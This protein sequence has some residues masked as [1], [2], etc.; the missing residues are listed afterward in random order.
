MQQTDALSPRSNS[1]VIELIELYLKTAKEQRW[2][3]VAIAMTA[4]PNL[5]ACD[6]A[7]DVAL[8]LAQRDALTLL[9]GKVQESIDN[10]SLP[11]RDE[12]LDASYACYSIVNAP[13]G[14][15][16]ITWLI[17]Q[18]M[19]RVRE[20]AP[21]PLKVG[22]W[23]G[24]MHLD[25]Q[26]SRWLENV[27]R[28]ALKLIG[29][30][31][32]KKAVYGRHKPLYVARDIVAAVKAGEK[33]PVLRSTIEPFMLN[34]VTITLREAVYDPHRN[35][36][37]PA[38]L[39][40]AK[41]LTDKGEAVIFVRDTDKAEERLVDFQT[42]PKASRDLDV[43]MSLYENAKANLFVQN[44]PAG[45]AWY[46]KAPWLQFEDA[47]NDSVFTPLWW[48]MSQGINPGEQFP[49]SAENQRMVWKSDTYENLVSAWTSLAIN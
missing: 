16:F 21:A 9:R 23:Q 8:E 40:F 4:Y 47:G 11:D 43:R 15:D 25:R 31:E 12:T 19:I 27:F 3:H 29:A 46:S 10:W 17:D 37:L 20:G 13:I 6:Y 44:G 48:K 35:S 36:N 45:L 22:F 1:A 34:H 33:T 49:W 32:D 41:Y 42:C 30:V 18:E 28:P 7:G 14:Y 26:R 38:W 2:D 39:K 24:R 5:A